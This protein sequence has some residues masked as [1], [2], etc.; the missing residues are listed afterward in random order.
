MPYRE[1]VQDH[2]EWPGDLHRASFAY[3]TDLISSPKPKKMTS[4]KFSGMQDTQTVYGEAQ[5]KNFGL[6][7]R[8]M[9]ANQLVAQPLCRTTTLLPA[10]NSNLRI[11]DL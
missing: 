9:T 8:H 7:S 1:Y 4:I 10:W 3:A 11:P 6:R 5:Y 2:E